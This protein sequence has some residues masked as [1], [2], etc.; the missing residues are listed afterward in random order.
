MVSRKHFYLIVFGQTRVNISIGSRMNSKSPLTFVIYILTD[1]QPETTIPI[2]VV[3]FF[4]LSLRLPKYKVSI[5]SPF[6]LLK[7]TR[8]CCVQ[9][10][11]YQVRA[12]ELVQDNRLQFVLENKQLQ[13][14]NR[15]CYD[16][17]VFQS[18]CYP[19]AVQVL[20]FEWG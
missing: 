16:C 19:N 15:K 8:F 6:D 2:C 12:N 9:N 3:R 5:W 18:T 7:I 13:I 11:Y 14:N 20:P 10:G 1:A 4:P 17:L